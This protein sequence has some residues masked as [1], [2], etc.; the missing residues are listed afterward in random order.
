MCFISVPIR[1]FLNS[2]IQTGQ[3]PIENLYKLYQRLAKAHEHLEEFESAVYHYK[4]IIESIELSKVAKNQKLQ[5]KNE[6]EKC[7]SLC[8]KRL[9]A[10]NFTSLESNKKEATQS[11]FPKYAATHPQIQNASGF[12]HF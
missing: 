8:K 9:I 3:Y 2:S 7:I 6:A 11:D 10:Q 1:L 4:K 5:T 12:V